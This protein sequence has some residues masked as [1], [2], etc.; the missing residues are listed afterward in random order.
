VF[1]EEVGELDWP[2]SGKMPTYQPYCGK[3]HSFLLPATVT[4]GAECISRRFNTTLF[5]TLFAVFATLLHR[6]TGQKRIVVGTVT[7]AGRDELEVQHSMGYLLNPVGI[8]CEFLSGSRF[9]EVLHSVR[10][11]ILGALS[12]DDV[13]YEQVAEAVG[14]NVASTLNPLFKVAASLEPKVPDLGDGWDLTPMDVESGG[15]RWPLYFVW[16]DRPNGISGRVQYNPSIFTF[17]TVTALVED[18]QVLLETVSRDPEL[19]ISELPPLA[20][21]TEVSE[22]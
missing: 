21:P 18:F 19:R 14:R 2:V 1:A 22:L 11:A 17:D 9:S 8:L 13:P 4:E 10:G 16:E 5:V 20:T 7:P 6:Y 3:I 15:T 12:H